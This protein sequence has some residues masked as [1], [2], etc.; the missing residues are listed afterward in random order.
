MDT[1]GILSDL[2]SDALNSALSTRATT[3]KH[4][5]ANYMVS[6][7]F[8]LCRLRKGHF[9]QIVQV[10]TVARPHAAIDIDDAISMN[11]SGHLVLI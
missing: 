2:D 8:P 11:R 3:G 4:V 5:F 9:S 10:G 6:L 7:S 1:D